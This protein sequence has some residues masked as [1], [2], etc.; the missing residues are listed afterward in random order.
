MVD[1]IGRNVDSLIDHYLAV[2]MLIGLFILSVIGA[3]DVRVVSMLGL[4]LC[5]TGLAQKTA[6]VASR[7]PIS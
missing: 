7:L 5:V 1:W 3:G 2:C 4:L 6:R